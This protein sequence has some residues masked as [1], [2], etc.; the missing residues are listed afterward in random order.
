MMAAF[1]IAMAMYLGS[2]ALLTL[3]ASRD[4]YRS[5]LRLEAAIS[6]G[7][8]FV[9]GGFAALVLARAL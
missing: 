3:A 9:L 5:G 1:Q 7:F 2:I 6:S 8:T 4:H